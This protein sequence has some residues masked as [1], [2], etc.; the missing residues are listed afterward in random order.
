MGKQEWKFTELWGEGERYYRNNI[1]CLEIYWTVCWIIYTLTRDLNRT[2][3]DNMSHKIFHCFKLSNS[4]KIIFTL[5]RFIISHLLKNTQN[6]YLFCIKEGYSKRF[7]LPL[8]EN[9]IWNLEQYLDSQNFLWIPLLH[10][11]LK[12]LLQETN[13]VHLPESDMPHSVLPS[14]F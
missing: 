10:P 11:F 4:L 6:I 5:W 12:S 8:R 13:N 7:P 3:N 1:C 14:L 9:G 2:E